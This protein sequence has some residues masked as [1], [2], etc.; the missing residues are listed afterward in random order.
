[1]GDPDYFMEASVKT[2][3]LGL[4]M[5]LIVTPLLL[6]FIYI[7]S[8]TPPFHGI[9]WWRIGGLIPALL[10]LSYA[11]FLFPTFQRF[12]IPFHAVQLAG[13]IIMMTGISADL[14]TRP[15]FPQFGRTALAS[16]LT[17][18]IFTDFAFAAGAR[19]YLLAILLP[20]LAAMSVYI[21]AAG[22]SLTQME[23]LWLICNPAAVA[24]ALSL[25][26]LFQ[27]RLSAKEFRVRAELSRA[28]NALRESERK[29]HAL[30][31]NAEV[32]MF[33]M[34]QNGS[35]VIDVNRKYLEL[36]GR[37]RGEM[38]GKPL[39][40]HWADP[41]EHE[42]MMAVLARDAHVTNFECRIRT[43]RGEE[44]SCLASLS[45]LP[46]QQIVEG[47]VLDITER[48]RLE[49][50][51]ETVLKRLEFVMA[52]TRTG[53]DIIDE[54]YIVRYVDPARLRIMGQPEGRL[55]YG[56]FRGRFSLCGDCAMQR[57]L[58]THK[59]Q[60]EE[61][62][63]PSEDN[64][65]TQVT[66]LPYQDE[67]GKWLV[68][69]VIVDISER[70]KAEAE[71]LDLERRVASAQ[72]LE[73][74]G[75]LAGGVAHN[76]NNLLTVILGHADLLKGAV[77]KDP[78]MAFSVLEIIKASERSRDLVSQLLSLG[79]QPVMNFRPIDLNT[80]IRECG[81]ILRQTLREN[82]SIDYRLSPSPCPVAAD[83][84]R[85]EQILLNLASNAQDAIPR[86]GLIEIA[87]TEVVLD[88]AVARRHEDIPPGRYVR[89]T[90]GDNGEGM[91]AETLGKIFT[92]FFT[93]KEQGKGTGLGLFSTYGLVKQHNGKIEV[94]SSP[95][96]GTRFT[97]YLPRIETPLEEAKPA[98]PM[99]SPQGT[100]TILLVEDE[101]PIRM[102]ISYHLRSL[103]Y[104]VLEASDGVSGLQVFSEYGEEVHLLVT[105]VVMPRMNGTDLRD[106]LREQSPGLK[107]LFVSG[108]Q[109][110]VISTYVNGAEEM[111]LMLKPFSGQ[112]LACRVREILDR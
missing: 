85:I 96:A 77:S 10:F 82:I 34:L 30:F 57:A 19:K 24:L 79:K 106:R 103:G 38:I 107:V 108:Y 65:Q 15:D 49:A 16:S 66:A 70:Q 62:T 52:T 17:I 14:A 26:A 29:Y 68:A 8:I 47:S 75:I 22:A 36:T 58:K 87:T 97:I 78:S 31:E 25:L 64:R 1:M 112:D 20:P 60:V 105:D 4:A 104:K 35:K 89:L 21:V 83:P 11:L 27:E 59:I 51:R 7:D 13:L 95:H 50:D 3:N 98:Q 91:A 32:G 109:K 88:G 74:L 99:A 67:S 69:E 44:R 84:G 71:R 18:C 12:A 90:F 23:Q 53:L 46:E 41:R 45:L 76:F 80:V 73:G 93:T 28:E 43:G 92:P 40:F 102:M 63:L 61:Q 6:G 101:E 110:E 39:A 94:E 33:Q 56:Y 9:F 5:S 100:E 42:E 72:K 37:S 54:D 111:D 86:E 81:T 2:R 55:C 48:K